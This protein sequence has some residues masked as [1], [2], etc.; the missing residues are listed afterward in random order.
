MGTMNSIY[1]KHRPHRP[2]D[3]ILKFS[4]VGYLF[5]FVESNANA[6]LSETKDAC[7]LRGSFQR[8]TMIFYG[9]NH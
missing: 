5:Y 3:S 2:T 4:S 8:G 9:K 7:A 6:L 1:I